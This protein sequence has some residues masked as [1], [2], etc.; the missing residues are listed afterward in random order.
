MTVA[1]TVL[2]KKHLVIGA[3]TQMN[4]GDSR[5]PGNNN[6]ASKIFTINGTYIAGSG[7]ALYE[8]HYSRFFVRQ[9][10]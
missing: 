7:W 1:V 10:E 2:K 5:T 3:D 4:F 6:K 8:Q 9:K